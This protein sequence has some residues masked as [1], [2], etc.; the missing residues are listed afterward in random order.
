VSGIHYTRDDKA[1]TVPASDID[2]NRTYR[3]ALPDFLT[4]GGDGFTAAMQSIPADRIQVDRNKSMR[5]V[6]IDVLVKHPQPIEA[7]V[8]G[9]VTV[10]NGPERRA[11]QP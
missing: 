6:M 2:P 8:E 3:V 5:D 11:I 10:L 7:K 1:L 4:Q 9:R